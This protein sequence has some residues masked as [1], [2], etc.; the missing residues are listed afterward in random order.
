[1]GRNSKGQFEKGTGLKNLVGNTYGKLTVVALDKIKSGRSYWLCKCQCGKVK[2]IR[3]DT[4]QKIQSCGCV[5]KT[6][7][8]QNLHIKTNHK[9]SNHPAYNIW[10]KMMDRC[11]KPNSRFYKNYGGRNIKVCD[12]WHNVIAFCEWADKNGYIANENLSIERIDVNGNYEPNNCKW[13]KRNLQPYNKTNTL[14]FVDDDGI[15]KSIAYE[16]R[17]RGADA[18]KAAWRYRHGIREPKYIF[19]K[20]SL[21]KD[22]PSLFSAH[23]H[24]EVFGNG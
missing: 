23:R 24:K 14:R 1:M 11:Y 15:E 8:I 13:I 4:L 22:F 12:E 2:T 19:Y 7:D 16:A 5:K 17:L 9:M 6:Q 10:V 3:G 20:G 21:H 18:H